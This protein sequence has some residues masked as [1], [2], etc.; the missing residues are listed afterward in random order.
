MKG[1]LLE[2]IPSAEIRLVLNYEPCRRDLPQILGKDVQF[3]LSLVLGT[4]DIDTV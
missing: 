4:I 3:R 2:S 1:R